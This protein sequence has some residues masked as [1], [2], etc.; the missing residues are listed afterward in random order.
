M[1]FHLQPLSLKQRQTI[2]WWQPGS[3][4]EHCRIFLADGAIRS[5]KTVSMILSFLL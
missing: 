1:S 5:G 2:L 3:G 4:H